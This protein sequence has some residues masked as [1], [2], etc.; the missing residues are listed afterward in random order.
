MR[1]TRIYTGDDGRSHF[2]DIEVKVENTPTGTMRSALFPAAGIGLRESDGTRVVD[3]HPAPQRQF[4]LH[5]AGEVELECGDGTKRRF[6]PGDIFLADDTT[7]QGHILRDVGGPHRGVVVPV[8]EDFD[9]D[10]LRA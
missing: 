2:E 9:L 4:V 1:I 7:G 8:G 5:L 10:S 3:F 6:G